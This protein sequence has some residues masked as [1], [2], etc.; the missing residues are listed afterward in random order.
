MKKILYL[1]IYKKWFDEILKGNKKFEYRNIKPYWTKRL[2][3]N[4]KNPINYTEIIFKNGYSKNCP[5][6]RVE[7]LSLEEKNNRYV[8]KLGKILE[9]NL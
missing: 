5:K 4:N 8:I 7:F 9:K 3:D 6:L 2:F 1:T